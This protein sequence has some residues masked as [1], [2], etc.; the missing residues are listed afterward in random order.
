MVTV[1]QTLH[2]TAVIL[3]LALSSASAADD[4]RVNINF[5][6]QGCPTTVSPETIDLDKNNDKIHWYALEPD[7]TP[8]EGGFSIIF[9]PFRVGPPLSTNRDNL[10]SPPVAGDVPEGFNTEFKYSIKGH[11]CDEYLD[12]MI[13]IL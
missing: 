6:D 5:N 13:R 3:L 9:D 12:P 10:K 11:S 4:K 8:Y 1:Q 2:S 7:G